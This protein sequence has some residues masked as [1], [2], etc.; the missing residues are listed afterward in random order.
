MTIVF[1]NNRTLV[2]QDL[3]SIE[4]IP[5]YDAPSQQYVWWITRDTFTSLDFY[6]PDV[7]T[8]RI[9]GWIGVSRQTGRI[10]IYAYTT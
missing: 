8:G 4:K 7:L 6:K 1:Q 9:H 2:T 5:E 3:T 10:Y